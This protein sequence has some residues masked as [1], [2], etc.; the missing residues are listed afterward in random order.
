MC[1]L[2]SMA[3]SKVYAAFHTMPNVFNEHKHMKNNKISILK[4]TRI[5]IVQNNHKTWA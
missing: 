3:H 5:S 1:G 4:T 2:I